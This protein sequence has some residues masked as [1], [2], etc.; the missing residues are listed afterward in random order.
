MST[1]FVP[2]PGLVGELSDL[3]GV[4]RHVVVLL[5][6]SHR[7]LGLLCDTFGL[8]SLGVRADAVVVERLRSA[9]QC[10][11][12]CVSLFA[13]GCRVD[14][15][16]QAFSVPG[17]SVVE[18]V[19]KSLLAAVFIADLVG[20]REFAFLLSVSCLLTELQNLLLRMLFLMAMFAAVS[21]CCIMLLV[22]QTAVFCWSI[23]RVCGLA[24]V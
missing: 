1:P 9:W 13:D 10:L 5:R 14:Q 12:F 8:S 20:R 4:G 19:R 11:D 6:R 2:K 17:G 7:V 23:S 18:H 3:A 15:F 22:L 24:V 21:P 16:V